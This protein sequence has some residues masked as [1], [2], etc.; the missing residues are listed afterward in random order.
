MK[1]ITKTIISSVLAFAMIFGIFVSVFP[2]AKVNAEE[3]NGTQKV[4][5]HKL[6]LGS[7]ED[8]KNWDSDKVQKGGYDGTQDLTQLNK[9]LQNIGGGH[10]N[11]VKEISGVYFA[12]QKK[13]NG[14]WKYIKKDG[15]EATGLEDANILG[16]LTGD[17][18][19]EFDV[20][21]LPAGEYQIVEVR[22]KS[23]YVGEKGETLT[24]Q[25]AVPVVITLP[26]MKEDG[27]IK[28]GHVYPKN[29]QEKPQIDKN[30]E[31]K[32]DYN[33]YQQEKDKINKM[34]GQEVPYE[35]KTKLP[36]DSKYKTLR[37]EDTMTKG[38]T[39]KKGL[40]IKAKVVSPEENIELTKDVD[41]KLTENGSGFVL[42]FTAKGLEKIEGFAKKGEVEFILKYKAILNGEAVVDNPEKNQIKFDY[43]NKPRDFA[44]PR[45]K[46]VT[47]K[48]QAIEVEKIWADGN[49]PAGAKVTYYL[50]EKGAT[51][52]E[53]KVVASVT[54]TAPDFKHKFEGL[55]ANKKYYVKEVVAG[56]TPEYK[57]EDGKVIITNKKTPDSPTPEIPT[58]P[59]V[60]TYGKKFVKTGDKV[61]DRLAGAEFIVGND[62]G[63]FLGLKDDAIAQAD[64]AAYDKAEKDYQDAIAAY[65]ALTKAQQQ[66]AEGQQA[67]EKIEKAKEARDKAFLKVRT[68]YVW[69]TEDKAVKFTSNKNG[70]FEVTGLEKGKYKL[71]EVKAPEGY[72]LLSGTI[73]FEIDENSYSKAGDINYDANQAGNKDAKQ[74]INKKVTI[75][76]TG[77]VGTIIFTVVGITLMGVAVYAMKRRNAEEK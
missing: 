70:Q 52:E 68:G 6:L 57:V 10:P 39:Y 22:E 55:D 23:T 64:K 75:P 44:N 35:V 67:K 59:E 24:S 34:I 69:T 72:A 36:K 2:T 71:K 18:G 40:D 47:P 11:N 13:V 74:V 45:D 50:Y 48:N 42:N 8:L 51:P 17:N 5:L 3:P 66:G 21:K 29:I 60:V 12:W 15:T 27:V 53:D 62:K 63:Q 77:G 28:D 38:L 19:K 46:E 41:Y 49:A 14:E 1:K 16:G 58:S 9:I 33:K 32:T 31:G 76:Q 25:K 43:G 30:I 73:D 20:S 37:W 26:L 7:K 54:K 56:Y 61:T 4:T 65:N